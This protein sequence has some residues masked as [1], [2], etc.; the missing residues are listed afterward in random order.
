M[1]DVDLVYFLRRGFGDRVGQGFV[2]DS[3]GEGLPFFCGEFFGVLE[4]VDGCLEND[5]GGND[6]SGEASSADLVA[7]G[8]EFGLAG[9]TGEGQGHG[10]IFA[11]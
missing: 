9:K 4:F 6:W 1:E 11:Y 3:G 10:F 7:S 8:F 5:G 2:F